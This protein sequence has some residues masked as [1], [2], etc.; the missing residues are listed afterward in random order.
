VAF[1]ELAS[2]E[3]ARM[4]VADGMESF[5]RMRQRFAD[6]SRLF[7]GIGPEGIMAAH[8]VH[9]RCASLGH[10]KRPS[11]RLPSGA[12]YLHGAL[13]APAWRSAGLGSALR[14]YVFR[15]LGR[16]EVRVA[17]SAVF[18]DN[19]GA[20]RW[21]QA[22]GSWRWGSVTYLRWRR[23]EVWW[24]RVTPAGRRWPEL[25]E[26]LRPGVVV[27]PAAL[28]LGRETPCPVLQES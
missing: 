28:H 14:R 10:V 16:E 22:N 5:E 21:Q 19:A 1:R 6:G 27:A 3:V 24:T 9:P 13:T 4:P 7:A 25:L 12:V 15:C 18:P 26:G 8:W 11:L 17:L 2:E 23:Y 20:L